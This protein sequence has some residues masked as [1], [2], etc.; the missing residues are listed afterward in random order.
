MLIDARLTRV[1]DRFFEQINEQPYGGAALAIYQDGRPIL[2]IWG[3]QSRPGI[4]WEPDTKSVI[5]S[6]TKGITTLLVL[7]SIARGEIDIDLPVAHYWPEFA[8]GGKSEITVKMV[9]R[10]RA[11]LNTTARDMTIEEILDLIP[12]EEM[13]AAQEPIYPPDSGFIYHALSVGH[14]LGK[15]LFNVTGKRI[16]Q[17]LQE[18][19]AGRLNIPMWIGVPESHILDIATLK[20]D[21]PDQ[22]P[23][24]AHGTKEYWQAHAMGYGAHQ[25]KLD[26]VDGGWN[27]P[28]LHRAEIAGAGGITDARSLA[29]MYSA[30][31]TETDGIR[32]VDEASIREAISHPNP[33]DNIFNEPQPHPIH[34][35]GFIVANNQHCPAISETTFG[36]NGFG[37]QQGFGDLDSKIGFGY[38]TNWVPA[39]ADG[40]LRHRELTRILIECL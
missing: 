4:A 24:F 35:L 16:N 26:S 8:A 29:K 31:V 28:R 17:L 15:I 30:A 21:Q 13:F 6:A 3:G 10:H 36:H 5:F 22:L 7:R 12:V 14:L 34:S 20:S 2:D 9:L 25:G 32:I 39:V 33:G 18:E 40:M 19:I 37:G 23:T 11:G 38:I 1:A 27:D